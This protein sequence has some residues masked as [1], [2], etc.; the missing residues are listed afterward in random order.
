MDSVAQFTSINEAI[1]AAATEKEALAHIESL[2]HPDTKAL[3]TSLWKIEQV[4]RKMAAAK[5]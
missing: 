4:K 3:A 5:S 2:R 1:F